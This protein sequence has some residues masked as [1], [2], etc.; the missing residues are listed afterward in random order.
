MVIMVLKPSDLSYIS[1]IQ[2]NSTFSPASDT[3]ISKTG[4]FN[5]MEKGNTIIYLVGGWFNNQGTLVSVDKK[6]YD[7]IAVN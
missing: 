1:M 2:I 3:S 6:T 7:L 4:K 5:I